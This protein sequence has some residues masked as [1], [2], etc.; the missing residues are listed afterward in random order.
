[1]IDLHTHLLP[2]VDDGSESLAQSEAVLKRFAEQGVKAVCCT[3]HLRASDIAAAPC[4][5][6]DELL[7]ELAPAAPAGL[8]L[9][10][11]FEIM[12]DVPGA[13]IADRC[14]TLA[15]SRYVLVEF[16]RLMPAEPSVEALR[17]I[18]AQGLVPVLA[19]PERYAACSVPMA[20]A[21][22]EAGAALQVDA[23]T[24]LGDTRRAERARAVVEAGHAAIIASDNHGDLR[25]LSAAVEWLESHGART[26]AQLLASVNPR[27][28]LEDG[29][30]EPV[31]PVRF[32]RS[33]YTTLK[34]FVIGGKE[35]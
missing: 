30:L 2:G 25:N 20:K 31:P 22:Q 9:E 32:R 15:R 33:W 21:W 29:D 23:T 17:A 6:M 27:A 5:E 14:L 11:G 19:H 35:A 12:L 16:Q 3:P 7:A 24:L 26:Q 10:R 34:A 28:M 1:M 13:A 4:A 18:V 8:Q